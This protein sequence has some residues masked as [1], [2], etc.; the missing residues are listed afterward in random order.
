[1]LGL[2][3]DCPEPFLF[4]SIP[5]IYMPTPTQND[6]K[7]AV[8]QA[9]LAYIEPGA[10]LGIGGG[11]TVLTFI[12]LLAPYA[13]KIPGA[14]AASTVS[15]AAL[16]AIGIPVLDLN[17]ID[18]ISVYI[19]GADEID[20]QLNMIKGGGAALTREKIIASVSSRFICIVDAS[21]HVK[22]LGNFP[23]PVEVV[24]MARASATRALSELTA[25][26]TITL[27][28]GDSGFLTDNGNIIL[29]VH[30]LNITNPLALETQIN[31]IPGVVCNGIFSQNA[32]HTCLSASAD[33][34]GVIH[35]NKA[36]R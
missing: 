5:L 7:L 27:R 11:S 8:A 9:A 23:L 10:V 29:D 4:L 1:V 6:L 2:I 17:A 30:G 22:T 20:P 31:Q 18:R 36:S 32:A 21:K 15:E 34:T 12:G 14:V 26:L 25:G 28:G 13:G 35:I 33:E 24:P 16:K 3:L 19:D